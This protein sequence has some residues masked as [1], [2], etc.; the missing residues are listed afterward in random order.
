MSAA[1]KQRLDAWQSLLRQTETK[2]VS[3]S[4]NANNAT[5]LGLTAQTVQMAGGRD[6]ATAFQAGGDLMLNLIALT[7]MC[8]AN[9]VIIMQWP[10]SAASST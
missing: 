8:D 5:A 4:C 1:D 10:A 9:R 2:V 3:A 7:M 6:T